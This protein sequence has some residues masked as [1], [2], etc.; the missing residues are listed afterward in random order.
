MRA[1]PKHQYDVDMYAVCKRMQA[2]CVFVLVY[3]CVRAK[4]LAY[5]CC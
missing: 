3:V 1:L 2:R 5:A 4:L